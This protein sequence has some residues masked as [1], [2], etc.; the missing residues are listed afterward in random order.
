VEEG[1]MLLDIEL[2]GKVNE[3]F[4]LKTVLREDWDFEF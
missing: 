3:G 1:L 2:K 4:L